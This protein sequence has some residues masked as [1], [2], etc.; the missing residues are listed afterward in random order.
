MKRISLGIIAVFAVLSTPSAGAAF[1]LDEIAGAPSEES[2][3]ERLALPTVPF[4]TEANRKKYR[5]AAKF[6]EAVKNEALVRVWDGRMS[7]YQ[8]ADTVNELEYFTYELGEYFKSLRSYERT[9]K[10]FYRELADRNLDRTR[11]SYER[12]QAV[13]REK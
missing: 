2:R 7:S 10:A 9:G 11:T 12:L 8:F 6:L 1:F 3:M 4:R 13:T 5:D